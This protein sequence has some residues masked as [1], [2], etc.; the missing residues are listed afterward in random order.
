MRRLVII[1][2]LAALPLAVSAQPRSIGVRGGWAGE[3]TAELDYQHTLVQDNFIELD[4]GLFGNGF[5]FSAVYNFMFAQLPAGRG[6]WNFY[7]GPGASL[8]FNGE[9]YAAIAAQIGV[10]YRFSFPLYIAID[11][12]PSAPVITHQ[13]F[14]PR[15]IFGAGL[16]L[17]LAF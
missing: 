4:L 6:Q 12:R 1:L 2:I 15:G 3:W 16:S 9:L 5:R 7:T 14:W 10:E 13:G 11:L 17:G 8:A